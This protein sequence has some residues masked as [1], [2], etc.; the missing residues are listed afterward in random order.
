MEAQAEEGLAVDS[1]V[2]VRVTAAV[3][4]EMVALEREVGMVGQMAVGL[5]VAE[6]DEVKVM[7]GVDLV[8]G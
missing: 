4:K 5:G 1:V 7:E 2:V 6:W 3:D 8:D